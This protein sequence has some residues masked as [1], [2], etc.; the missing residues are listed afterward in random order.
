MK[1]SVSACRCRFKRTQKSQPEEGIA[2][3]PSFGLSDVI[4]IVA[5]GNKKSQVITKPVYNYWLDWTHSIDGD[6]IAALH[7]EGEKLHL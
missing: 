5:D 2:I 3:T 6:A 7:N 4:A 1:T